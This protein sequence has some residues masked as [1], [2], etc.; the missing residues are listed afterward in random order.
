MLSLED[1]GVY[2]WLDPTGLDA[3][4][5]MFRYQGYNLETVTPERAMAQQKVVKLSQLAHALPEE[6]QWVSATERRR[7]VDAR[8]AAYNLRLRETMAH[9]LLT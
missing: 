8:L 6:T 7:Q 1:P 9:Q 5:M 4:L 2:N 3:G